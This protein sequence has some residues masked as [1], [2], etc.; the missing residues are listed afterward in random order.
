MEIERIHNS[1]LSFPFK[2]LPGGKKNGLDFVL[3]F[4]LRIYGR[5][6]V[7]FAVLGPG[8][9]VKLPVTVGYGGPIVTL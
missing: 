4:V 7:Y 5:R 9:T 3:S 8:V 6:I 2:Q 1:G